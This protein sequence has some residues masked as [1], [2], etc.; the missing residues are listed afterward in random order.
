MSCGSPLARGTLRRSGPRL[1]EGGSGSFEAERRE[2]LGGGGTGVELAA[3]GPA[4]ELVED[5]G[6]VPADVVPDPLGGKVGDLPGEADAAALPQLARGLQ[7][8][9]VRLHRRPQLADAGPRGPD[10]LQHRRA[11]GGVGAE[12]EHLVQLPDGV[13][14]P[15]A[16]CLVDGEHVADLQQPRLP[17]LDAVPHFGVTTTTVVSAA[18]ITSTSDWPTPTVS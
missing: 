13:T 3:L 7:V 18:C 1:E 4:D 15:V 9:A 5:S 12:I 11:P 10:G 16:V 17:C 6:R 8:R 2:E 14:A